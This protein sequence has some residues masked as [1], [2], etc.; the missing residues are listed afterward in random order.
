[1]ARDYL[2]KATL[3]AQSG[4]S[5]VHELVQGILNDIEEGGD[6]KAMEYAAKFD[7]YDGN[8]ILTEEEIAAA[9]DLVPQKLKDDIQFAHDNVKRFAEAQKWVDS[10]QAVVRCNSPHSPR[11]KSFRGFIYDGR[12]RPITDED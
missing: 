11:K 9:A 4:A 6:A 3:T 7:K 12:N 10:R 2:K 8:V 5:D 1:M